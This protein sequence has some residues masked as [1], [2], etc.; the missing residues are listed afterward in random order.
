MQCLFQAF[1]FYKRVQRRRAQRVLVAVLF[2]QRSYRNR[3]SFN[4]SAATD[5]LASAIE[6]H[7]KEYQ[8]KKAAKEAAQQLELDAE[9]RAGV[10]AAGARCRGQG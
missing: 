8:E 1:S 4:L 2:I 5:R 7:R 9:V 3:I 6:N 10:R